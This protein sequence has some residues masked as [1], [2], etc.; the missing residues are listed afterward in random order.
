MTRSLRRGHR[1]IHPWSPPR[2]TTTVVAAPFDRSLFSVAC[3]SRV[4]IPDCHTI[5][6][7]Q[8][9]EPFGPSLGL[10]FGLA[11]SLVLSR[12]EVEL[13][14]SALRPSPVT[15][16]RHAVQLLCPLLT[17]D[18]RSRLLA[19][20]SVRATCIRT[21]RSQQCL[22]TRQTSRGKSIYF[23]RTTAGFTASAFDG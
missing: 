21:F 2:R 6:P 7:I 5:Y 19:N 13:R 9:R 17:S 11:G 8:H 1:E 12:A 4:L 14:P 3:H 20:P 23:L 16:C 15:C 22:N 18:M 10:R